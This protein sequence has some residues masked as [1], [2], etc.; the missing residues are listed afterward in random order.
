MIL[1]AAAVAATLY[2]DGVHF[3]DD[4]FLAWICHRPVQWADGR[5]VEPKTLDVHGR[6]LMFHHNPID[7]FYHT[8][9]TGETINMAD[10][11]VNAEHFRC[12]PCS[13]ADAFPVI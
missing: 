1:I 4:A 9:I 8:G 6:T 13:C 5:P 11:N 3:D 2:A 7:I 10:T 12:D